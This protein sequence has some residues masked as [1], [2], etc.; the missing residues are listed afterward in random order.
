MLHM[1]E[2]DKWRLWLPGNL[3]FGERR[4]GQPGQEAP[5]F[6]PPLGPVVFDVELV[7]ILP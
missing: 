5:P 6:G 1:V 3:A 7:E 4:P 2:G